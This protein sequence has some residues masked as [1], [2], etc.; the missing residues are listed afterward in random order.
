MARLIIQVNE[1]EIAFCATVTDWNAMLG[2]QDTAFAF[3]GKRQIFNYY[4]ARVEEK[5]QMK[6]TFDFGTYYPADLLQLGHTWSIKVKGMTVDDAINSL[7]KSISQRGWNWSPCGET[8]LGGTI[9]EFTKI[10]RK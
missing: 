8:N 5:I 7:L 4:A 2:T 1:D 3:E 6:D 10:E 9:F